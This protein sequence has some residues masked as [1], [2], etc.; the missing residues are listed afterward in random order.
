MASDGHQG[1]LQASLLLIEG[2]RYE[3]WDAGM[4]FHACKADLGFA[5]GKMSPVIQVV[6][7]YY[8]FWWSGT[9]GHFWPPTIKSL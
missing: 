5:P 9:T 7:M 8:I 6:M 4:H 1:S 2:L 3:A